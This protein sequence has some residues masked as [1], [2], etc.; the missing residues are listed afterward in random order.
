MVLSFG[1][2]EIAGYKSVRTSFKKKK[3]KISIRFL[4][5]RVVIELIDNKINNYNY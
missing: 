3:K 4:L 1:R 5:E 2:Y